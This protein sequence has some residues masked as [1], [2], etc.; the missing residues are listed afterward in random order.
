V[1]RTGHGRT[2]FGAELDAA[3]EN[4]AVGTTLLFANDRVRTTVSFTTVELVR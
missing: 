4:L 1:E 2:P 3:A